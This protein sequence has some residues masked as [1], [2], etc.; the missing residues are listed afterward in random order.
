MLSRR[1]KKLV[2][3]DHFVF[4]QNIHTL[5]SMRRLLSFKERCRS[6]HGNTRNSC[7]LPRK[8]DRRLRLVEHD[9]HACEEGGANVAF[10]RPAYY[11]AGADAGWVRISAFVSTSLA[12][13]K[14]R[15]RIKIEKTHNAPQS[16]LQVNSCQESRLMLRRS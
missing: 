3:A 11:F 12:A 1:Y 13:K 15:V 6:I 14:K 7:P 5:A 9:E 2:F 10:A 4:P 8:R 16:D